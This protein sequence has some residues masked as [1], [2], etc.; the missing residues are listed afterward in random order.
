MITIL[1]RAGFACLLLLAL[2]VPTLA[3]NKY[4]YTYGGAG[5]PEGKPNIFTNEFSSL[6]TMAKTNGY[7]L[8]MLFNGKSPKDLAQMQSQVSSPV[9]EFSKNN[10]S[11]S[12]DQ[13][14]ANS[15]KGDQVLITIDSHGSPNLSLDQNGNPEKAHNVSCNDGDCS[16]GKL[17]GVIKTL[18]AHGVKVAVIDLSCYSGLSQTLA[19]PKTCVISATS[20]DDV[21]RIGFGSMLIKQMKPGVSLE[22]A[23]LATRKSDD[24]VG[25]AEISTRAGRLATSTIQDLA[26][27]SIQHLDIDDMPTFHQEKIC[28]RNDRLNIMKKTMR[29]IQDLQSVVYAQEYIKA[30]EEYQKIYK[31]AQA[32]ADSIKKDSARVAVAYPGGH[33]SWQELAIYGDA[34]MKKYL[35]LCYQAKQRLLSNSDFQNYLNTRADFDQLTNSNVIKKIH[36]NDPEPSPLGKA[37][38]NTLY[39]EKMLWDFIYRKERIHENGK[40]NACADFQL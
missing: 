15:Q 19:N 3:S 14:V 9:K 20:Q 32:L 29:Q 36:S 17:A 38:L 16:V 5:D 39:P 24:A 12:L 31:V 1:S 23:F 11:K 10:Y 13:I 34:D 21:A 28:E 18:Q 25:R 40:G 30:S 4:M 6:A 8:Q 7:Q 2:P 22:D 33:C 35:P 37:A 26:G 27:E